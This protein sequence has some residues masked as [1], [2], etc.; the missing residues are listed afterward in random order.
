M[1]NTRVSIDQYKWYWD[2]KE[3]AQLKQD[4]RDMVNK[5]KKYAK[6]VN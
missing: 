5:S 6:I 2:S 3:K 1:Q 4:K